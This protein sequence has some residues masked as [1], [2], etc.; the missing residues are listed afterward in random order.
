MEKIFVYG[1]LRK[2]MYNYSY[3]ADGL[4]HLETKELKGYRMHSLGAYPFVVE[5]PDKSIVVDVMEVEPT[6]KRH[7]DNM[8]FG[9]G[10]RAKEETLDDHEG[11]IYYFET[12]RPNTSEVE[13]G[14]WV[15]YKEDAKTLL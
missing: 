8:E 2:G 7:I 3:F 9:A 11:T 14:D 4:N 1:S 12:P 6:F 5:D 10:Y 15:K 13:N